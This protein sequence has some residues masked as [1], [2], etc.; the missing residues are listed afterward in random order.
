MPEESTP[1]ERPKIRDVVTA[2][3]LKGMA[4]DAGMSDEAMGK[5]FGP[6][7]GL[8]AGGG[9]AVGTALESLGRSLGFKTERTTQLSL[10]CAYPA[11]VRAL[12]FALSSQRYGLT[13]AFDTPTGAYFEAILPRSIWSSPGTLQFDLVEQGPNAIQLTGTSDVNQVSD[14]GQGKR[15]LSGVMEKVEQF[16]RRLEG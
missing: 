9:E 10:A 1:G 13:T 5:L 7:L 14:W 3:D 4:N 8:S 15:A 16:A 6:L 12:V 2:D 11:A